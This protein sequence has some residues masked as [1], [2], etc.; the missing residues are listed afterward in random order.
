MAKGMA[1]AAGVPAERA[2]IVRADEKMAG[3]P[4]YNDPALTER[5]VR[6]FTATFGAENVIKV[7]PV[8]GSEDFGFFSL[9]QQIP[10]SM[11][12]LGATDPAKVADSRKNGTALPFLHSPLF[13]PLPEPTIRTGVIAMSAAILELLQ[14]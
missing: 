10:A 12:W 11:F 3:P 9:N 5:L 8:M 13:A 1:I 4:T 7:D 6:V 2:P 14:K